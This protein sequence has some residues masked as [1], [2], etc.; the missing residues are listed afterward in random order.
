ME[1]HARAAGTPAERVELDRKLRLF[2]AVYRAS[3]RDPLA[4]HAACLRPGTPVEVFNDHVTACVALLGDSRAVVA[5]FRALLRDLRDPAPGVDAACRAT[6]D[7]LSL[8]AIEAWFAILALLQQHDE[9]TVAS[10]A[11][12]EDLR[13]AIEAEIA[14][15]ASVG[16]FGAPVDEPGG[17]ED[18]INRVNHLKKWVLGVLHLRLVSNRRAERAR[19]FAFSLAAAVAMT[20]AVGLQLVAMWTVGT[21]SVPELG[22]T[23]YTFVGLAVGGYILKDGIKDRLKTWFQAGIPHWLFDR[24]FDLSVGSI[25]RPFGAVEETVTRLEGGEIPPAVL[26]LRETGEDPLFLGERAEE[27]VVHYRRR[28]RLN[29]AL[30]RDAAPEMSAVDEII[31]INVNR[32]L[33]R[34]DDPMRPLST[35]GPDARVVHV[36]APKTYRVTLVVAHAEPGHLERVVA[37]LSRD[38]LVRIERQR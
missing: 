2:A 26:A 5:R 20:F 37:V 23:L 16:L 25:E 32:W 28:V 7:F 1:S 38:G 29:A 9:P 35:L 30:A 22:R 34:M 10:T 3:M 31:R 13:A 33:R 15:R 36:D 27:D 11:L 4:S 18:Y 24:R 14:H 6:D 12:A 21:P 19:E 8:H 17:N